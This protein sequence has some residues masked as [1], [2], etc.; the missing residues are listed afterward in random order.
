MCV[1]ADCLYISHI[2]NVV[3]LP[4]QVARASLIAKDGKDGKSLATH[5][6]LDCSHKGWIPKAFLQYAPFCICD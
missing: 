1:G 4:F 6:A 2:G 3:C 5:S